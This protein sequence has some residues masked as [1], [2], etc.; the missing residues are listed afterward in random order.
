VAKKQPPVRKLQLADLK[1]ST[2]IPIIK[3]RFA[4]GPN[5]RAARQQQMLP[6]ALSDGKMNKFIPVLNLV[7]HNLFPGLNI[8]F[9]WKKF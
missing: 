8:T 1:T 6:R 7:F 5:L 2:T 9:L 3:K 4:H